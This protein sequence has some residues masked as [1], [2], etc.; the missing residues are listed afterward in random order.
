[1][2]LKAERG[3]EVT[4]DVDVSP[5]VRF[6]EAQWIAPKN[7]GSNHSRAAAYEGELRARVVMLGVTEFQARAV[8]EAHPDTTIEA[9]KQVLQHTGCLLNPD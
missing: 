4:F 8:P 9:L 3:E 1:M 5:K 2:I 6:S 7:H